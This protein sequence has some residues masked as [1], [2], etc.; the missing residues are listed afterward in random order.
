MISLSKLQY[1][2][3]KVEHSNFDCFSLLTK[4]L[5]DSEMKLDVETLDE[6]KDYLNNLSTSLIKYFPNLE[7]KEYCWV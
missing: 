1:W 3:S 7:Y 6:I 4:F 2:I 5:Q